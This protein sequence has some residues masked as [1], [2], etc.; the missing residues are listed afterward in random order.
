MKRCE[1]WFSERL[2]RDVTMARWGTF[3]TPV[4]LFPTAGGDAEEIERF[5]IVGALRSALEAGRIKIYSCDSVAGR[6]MLTEEGSPE[7]RMWVM[8]QYQEYVRYEVVPAIR[9]DCES[10]DIEVVVGGASIGAFQALAAVCRYPEVFSKAL[11]MSG[12]YDL[13]R[14]LKARPNADYHRSSPLDFVPALAGDHLERLRQRFVILA[15]GEGEAE[16][17]GQSWSVARVLGDQRVPNRVDSWG[18]D[19]K[20]DWPLWR[21]MVVEYLDE[22]VG[23]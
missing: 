11:C 17:I 2:H 23:E 7:H 21:N 6:A 19:W 16:N 1:T 8:N 20:H 15:S 14:F 4:L 9:M 3:G 13:E 10:D 12:T 22:L 5:H 18:P